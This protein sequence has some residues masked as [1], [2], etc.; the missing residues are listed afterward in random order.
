MNKTIYRQYDSQWGSLPYPSRKVNLADAGCGCLSVYHCAIENPKYKKLT[1]KQCWKYM[2]Q[3]SR[4]GQGTDWSGIEAGLKHY[5]FRVHWRQADDMDDIFAALKNS[6][7]MGV[8]LFHSGKAPNGTVW[9]S[10]GHYVAF[11]NYKI[12]DGKHLFYTKDSGLRGND[13]WHSYERSMKGCI[14]F[15]YICKSIEGETVKKPVATAPVKKPETQKPVETKPTKKPADPKP[16]WMKNG[17]KWAKKIA[18]DDSWKY[19]IFSS[20]KE[21]HDCPICKKHPKGKCH[22]WN[23]IGLIAALWHHGCGLPSKCNNHAI[24]NATAERIYNAKSDAAARK[25]AADHIGLKESD[26]K[27]IRNGRKNVSKKLMKPCDW[28]LMFKGNTYYHTWSPMGGGKVFDST[29]RDNNAKDIAIRDWK[30]Y[31]AKVVIRYVGK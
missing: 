13:G 23:C 18:A 4:S 21:A 28:C 7:K 8:I 27:V 19:V 14:K 6:K 31:S 1:V 15:V 5:G 9:T 17:I 3:F 16:D 2:K 24:D 29:N 26:I 20:C 11:T 30:N 22:G 12:K 10:S 25:I